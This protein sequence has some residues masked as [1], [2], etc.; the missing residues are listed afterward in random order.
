MKLITFLVKPQPCWSLRVQTH[1]CLKSMRSLAPFWQ[2]WF[3]SC[4]YS[5]LTFESSLPSWRCHPPQGGRRPFP[6]VAPIWR[7]LPS[8]M[9][10]PVWLT[11]SPN[12]ATP[13]TPRSSCPWLTHFS[14]L[15][16]TPWSTA[17]GTVSW[18]EL[19]WSYGE[20]KRTYTPSDCIGNLC[21][22]WL[23]LDWNLLK[24][25]KRWKQLIFLVVIMLSFLSSTNL[26][27]C[28]GIFIY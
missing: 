5:C 20:E 7:L 16:W 27:I 9:A 2:L 28:L 11:Y 21:D 4:W 22:I 17:W 26:V 25:N 12:L 15:C 6:P 24:F 8:S 23:W 14:R 13:Q 18:R 1:F 3:L 10:Q 19:W